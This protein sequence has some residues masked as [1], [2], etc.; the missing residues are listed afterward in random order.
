M[1]SMSSL[2]LSAFERNIRDYYGVLI[3]EIS[4]PT[5]Y[6]TINPELASCT[7]RHAFNI[8]LYRTLTKMYDNFYGQ[9]PKN[10]SDLEK[11][12]ETFNSSE[13]CTSRMRSINA[14]N[15]IYGR[16]RRMKY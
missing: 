7:T 4:Y 2:K 6:Y 13:M 10:W 8:V 5:I 14:C 1:S 11:F 15:V 16:G 9:I 3:R 12:L